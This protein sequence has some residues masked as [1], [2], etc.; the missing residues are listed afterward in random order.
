MR[1]V[2][3][4]GLSL[5]LCWSASA[6]A[7]SLDNL[8]MGGLWG[9]PAATDGTA[10]WWNPA[11]V[12]A[13]Q[14]TRITIEGAPT[15]ATIDIERAAPH[16]GP[17]TV[18]LEGVVPYAGAVSDFG[19]DGLGVGIGFGVPYV[20]GGAQDPEGGPVRYHLREGRIEA[21]DIMV[22]AGWEFSDMVAVGA[23]VHYLKSGW[24]ARVDQELM[25]DLAH[26][27]EALD[28]DP[29]YTDD[30]LE[31]PD[32]AATLD[33][34]HLHDDAVSFSAG[35]RV[36]PV[37]TV[38]I[39]VA[40]VHGAKVDNQG[41]VSLEF[42]C[43][44]EEDLLG[45]FGAQSRGLC[46]SA[47]D[48]RA[49]VAYALPARVH[50]GVQVRPTEQLAVEAMGGVVFWKVHDDYIITVSDITGRDA[51]LPAESVALIERTQAW[52]RDN[53]TSFWLGLDAKGTLAERFTIG[54]RLMLD[55]AAVPSKALIAN[56]FDTD[57]VITGV[58]FAVRPVDV[59]E[60]GVS[61]SHYF[62]Q[63]RDVTDSAFAM[64]LDPEAA[65]AERYFYPHG[66]GS[67]G[68]SIDRFGISGQVRF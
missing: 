45:R 59:V 23:A 29:G 37:E 12:A 58:L 18:R 53:Q 50:G 39:S 6:R 33:F 7:A 2:A 11:G 4:A 3:T 21:I 16:G 31:N 26:E 57:S 65:A 19:V 15:F 47:A 51:E 48:G 60:I 42:G 14:G 67:Y 49:S 27:I 38:A 13:G 34:Q 35:L 5:A 61:W 17:D 54:G 40:Y 66:N 32:Y 25:V 43:P 44:P 20:R 52:A 10:L 46:Y 63:T 41:E 1:G 8:E 28:Q 9:T 55:K 56:N 64:T 68:G 24:S 22:A 30:D 62:L 36:K